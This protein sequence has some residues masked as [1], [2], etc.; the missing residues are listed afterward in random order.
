MRLKKKRTISTL[1]GFLLLVSISVLTI[2]S[3]QAATNGPFVQQTGIDN[4]LQVAPFNNGGFDLVDIDNDGDYD[5]FVG[6]WSPATIGYFENTGDN[7]YPAYTQQTGANNPLDSVNLTTQSAPGFADLD[8]DGDFDTLIGTYSGG[9]LYYYENIGTNMTPNFVERT[10]VSNPFNG[11]IIEGAQP[12]FIDIDN[13]NDL[14]AF[15]GALDGTIHHYLNTGTIAS[16]NFVQQTG[17]DNPLSSVSY[18]RETSI[19][20]VDIDQDGDFDAFVGDDPGLIYYYENTGN[21]TSPAFVNQTGTDNPLDGVNVGGDVVPRFV[22]IDSDSDDDVF[23]FVNSGNPSHF[24]RNCGIYQENLTVAGSSDVSFTDGCNQ[25]I[26]N[27]NSV[28]LD[29][30]IVRIE[31]NEHPT[32]IADEAVMR[33]F[34]ITPANTNGRNATITFFFD[35]SEIPAGQT[36]D[37]LDV[38][39]WDG[40]NWSSPLTLD[41]T[42]DGD[43]RLCGSDPQSVRVTG[44]SDFSP[45][46]LKGNGAP[47]AV[48]LQSF[49]VTSQPI[50]LLLILFVGILVLGAVSLMLH[51]RK[52]Q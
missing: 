11:V 46:V 36:C 1:A 25:V 51:H 44:V 37:T 2:V 19:D 33:R 4:P 7:V 18:S 40:S 22:D 39:H 52:N 20:F 12:T 45:F 10:G 24:F 29:S 42:Y 47:T 34:N 50:S 32:S 48:S 49:S 35:S 23:M 26:I 41:S 31:G 15:F 5:A 17:A 30:T 3:V 14:D 28:D 8:N 43:G 9:I 16:P 38:Y 6:N 13:D 27:A 21:N